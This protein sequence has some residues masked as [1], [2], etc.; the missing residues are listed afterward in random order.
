MRHWSPA[1]KP[2][3]YDRPPPLA[4]P[5][6]RALV[7]GQRS[8]PVDPGTALRWIGDLAGAAKLFSAVRHI[9]Q[10]AVARIVDGYAAAVVADV[11]SQHIGDIDLDSQS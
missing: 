5:P 1:W 11:E 9:G 6:N 8:C 3:A 2:R 10:A 4:T 7:I